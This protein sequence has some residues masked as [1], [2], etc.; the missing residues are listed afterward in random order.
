[1]EMPHMKIIAALIFSIFLSSSYAAYAQTC[2]PQCS[3]SQNT[4]RCPP[5]YYNQTPVY[6]GHGYRPDGRQ[7]VNVF[8]QGGS[9]SDSWDTAPGSGTT[10][11]SM[12]NAV[13]GPQGGMDKWNSAVDT[14]SNPGT[15]Q[16]PPYYFQ[17]NQG[18][19]QTDADI[20]ISPYAIR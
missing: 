8:I 11:A 19:G 16:R 13:N 3:G 7:N 15:T 9:G 5:C 14:T 4:A 12:W 20:I 10:D 1:M 6:R 17:I 2:S 18:G